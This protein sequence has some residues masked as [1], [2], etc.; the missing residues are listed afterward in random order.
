MRSVHRAKLAVEMITLNGYN[1]FREKT[2]L[3][4]SKDVPDYLINKATNVG[5]GF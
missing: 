1:A 2:Y 4:Y 3:W 5:E